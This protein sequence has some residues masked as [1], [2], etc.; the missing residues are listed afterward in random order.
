MMSG[1]AF[2]L[3]AWVGVDGVGKRELVTGF[4]TIPTGHCRFLE[5]RE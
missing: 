1:V 5:W 2:W 3:H 4:R